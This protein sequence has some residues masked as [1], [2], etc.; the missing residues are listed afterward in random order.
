MSWAEM[1]EAILGRRDEIKGSRYDRGAR[2]RNFKCGRVRLYLDIALI[3]KQSN[4]KLK[5]RPRYRP[6]SLYDAKRNPSN[7]ASAVLILNIRLNFSFSS[8]WNIRCH[9]H[10]NIN[11]LFLLGPVLSKDLHKISYGRSRDF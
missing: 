9:K 8:I 6:V 4:L 7:A 3:T 2:K 1:D 5:T 11:F 10:N